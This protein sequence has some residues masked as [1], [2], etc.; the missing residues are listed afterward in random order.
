MERFGKHR[1]AFF[2]ETIERLRKQKATTPPA[3][4]RDIERMPGNPMLRGNP[5][6]AEEPHAHG[7]QLPLLPEGKIQ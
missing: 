7:Q 4:A 5:I 2:T 6:P 3:P 1:V